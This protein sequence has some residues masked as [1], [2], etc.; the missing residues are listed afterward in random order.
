MQFQ[1]G[2]YNFAFIRI[3]ETLVDVSQHR[4]LPN[5]DEFNNAL[6]ALLCAKIKRIIPRDY[7][8]KPIYDFVNLHYDNDGQLYFNPELRMSRWK[9]DPITGTIVIL[10]GP[11]LHD[12]HWLNQGTCFKHASQTFESSKSLSYFVWENDCTDVASLRFEGSSKIGYDL[13]VEPIIGI[14][15]SRPYAEYRLIMY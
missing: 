1:E 9:C 10:E 8:Y 11:V 12:M 5:Y 6:S 13:F 14:Y 2:N 4:C 7:G 3:S 15:P